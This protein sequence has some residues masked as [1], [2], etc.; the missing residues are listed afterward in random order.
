VDK[1]KDSEPTLLT[2]NLNIRVKNNMKQ[3]RSGECGKFSS[4]LVQF[5]STTES[6]SEVHDWM[7]DEQTWGH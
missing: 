7:S 6:E 4:A 3:N 5:K 1:D 2:L